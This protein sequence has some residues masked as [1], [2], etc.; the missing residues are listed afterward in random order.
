[1]DGLKFRTYRTAVVEGSNKVVSPNLARSLYDLNDVL[2][3]LRYLQENCSVYDYDC[4]RGA[5]PRRMLHLPNQRMNATLK[6]GYAVH[7]VMCLSGVVRL[8]RL[9]EL[10]LDKL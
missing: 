2:D 6:L 10:K 9:E 7:D 8:V 4:P 5:L 1:M 3:I